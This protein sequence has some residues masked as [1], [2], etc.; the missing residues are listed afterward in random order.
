[1]LAHDESLTVDRLARD[2]IRLRLAVLSACET[3]LPGAQIPNEVIGLPS[4]LVQAGACGVT[5][6]LWSVPDDST[7]RLMDRLYRLW[8]Q[9][10]HPATEALRLSQMSMRADGLA[11]PHHWAAFTYTG[12]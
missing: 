11:H 9:E 3:G 2:R 4:A 10:E 6:S 12:V 8:R 5:A 7:R 1:M